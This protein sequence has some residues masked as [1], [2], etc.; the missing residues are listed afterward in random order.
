MTDEKEVRKVNLDWE[1]HYKVT[2]MT[3]LHWYSEDIDP[4]VLLAINK[5]CAPD[6]EV[7]DLGTGPGTMAI[8]LTKLGFNV[9]ATDISPSAIAMAKERAGEI[10]SKI[11]FVIDDIRETKLTSLY[12]IIHDRG[13]FHVL[14]KEGIEKYVDN[15]KSLLKE[16]GILLLKTFSKQ[17][18][19]QDGPNKYDQYTIKEYFSDSFKIMQCEE[20]I[21][22]STLETDP[23]ALFCVLKRL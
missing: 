7:L 22:P 16:T 17:E 5:F 21:Y 11:R 20:T 13:C 19:K 4:E 1:E 8:E 2:P 18:T 14:S 12:D 15:V 23:K 6:S 10:A 9:T 3:K